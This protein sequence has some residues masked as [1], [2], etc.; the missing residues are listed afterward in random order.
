[1]ALIPM[2]V[3]FP[4]IGSATPQ[5]IQRINYGFILFIASCM[6]IGAVA[7]SLGLGKILVGVVMPI[8]QGQHHYVFFLIVWITLVVLNFVMTP[9]AME[10]A[11]TVP[12]ATL[13]LALGLN[14]MAIYYFMMNGVDQIIMPY[15]YA[16]YMIF[17]G[18]G[19]IHMKDFMKIMG[20]KMI[21]NFIMCF[22][23]LLPWWSFLGFLFK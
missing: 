2:L 20:T 15:Q 11:F 17:F 4:V 18:F 22:A 19:L 1:M 6:G 3:A 12:F 10:A 21:A 7:G 23:F 14:P 5:D 13:G 9:L 16:L 8:L